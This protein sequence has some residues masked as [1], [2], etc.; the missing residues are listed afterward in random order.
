MHGESSLMS[1]GTGCPQRVSGRSSH[2]SSSGSS[3][4]HRSSSTA[5]IMAI[6]VR[7]LSVDSG[8][9]FWSRTRLRAA[10]CTRISLS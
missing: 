7:L 1:A 9:C 6:T 10:T 3:A 4:P 8:Q 5:V 2:R